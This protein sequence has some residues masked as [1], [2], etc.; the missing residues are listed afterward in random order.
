M[1]LRHPVDEILLANGSP[2]YN[3]SSS[4]KLAINSR[5]LFRKCYR[6]LVRK[7]TDIYKASYGSS[8]LLNGLTLLLKVIGL[9]C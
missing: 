8:E 9:F 2:P 1:H 6:A 5:N 4:S 3:G 7:V